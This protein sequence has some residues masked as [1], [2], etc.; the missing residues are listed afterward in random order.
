MSTSF[1]ASFS[2]CIATMS[3]REPASG[4]LL[5]SA[6]CIGMVGV[7]GPKENQA[8]APPSISRCLTKEKNHVECRC[9]RHSPGRRQPAARGTDAPRAEEAQP[10]QSCIG[11]ERWRRSVGVYLRDGHLQ[12]APD[13]EYPEGDLARFE[14]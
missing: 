9:S 11:S 7:S 14:T 2:G 10:G 6:Y 5:S 1:L 3:S 4:W 8:Q 13:G 12:S